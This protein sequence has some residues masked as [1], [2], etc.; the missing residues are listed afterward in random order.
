MCPGSTSSYRAHVW[1][2]SSKLDSNLPGRH[3]TD[4]GRYP[5]SRCHITTSHYNPPH[6]SE[7]TIASGELVTEILITF[8][9]VQMTF[10]SAS[11]GYDDPLNIGHGSEQ[12]QSCCGVRCNAMLRGRCALAHLPCQDRAYRQFAPVE[13]GANGRRWAGGP[14]VGPSRRRSHVLAS[15]SPRQP[16][17][18]PHPRRARRPPRSLPWRSLYRALQV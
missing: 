6:H 7:W 13:G 14:A 16:A 9:I 12:N 8:V 15:S 2:L 17:A 1:P 10:R 4:E 18:R 3:I 11:V 5:F